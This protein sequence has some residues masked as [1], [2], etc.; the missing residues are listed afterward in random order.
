MRFWDS[1]AIVPL[2]LDEPRSG[3]TREIL[4][5]SPEIIVWWGTAVECC[6][7]FARLQREGV[8]GAKEVQQAMRL[9]KMLQRSWT[10]IMPSNELRT[11]AIRLIPAHRLKAADSLQLAAALVWADN[12]PDGKGFVCLDEK[13]VVA[14]QV[15]G[16]SVLG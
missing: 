10:E 6:S 12:A 4:G 15:E 3:L 5:D 1:S 13:L 2:C 14:A 9:L 11:S 7:A 8:F 16:F